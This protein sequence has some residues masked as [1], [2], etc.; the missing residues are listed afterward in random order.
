MPRTR[1]AP[2]GPDALDRPAPPGR[3]LR[4][5]GPSGAAIALRICSERARL[6]LSVSEAARQLGIARS[7]YRQLEAGS[8]PR[9]S[10]LVALVDVL[11][12]DARVLAPELTRRR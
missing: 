6:G 11:G 12:M 10:T 7:T 1:T 5:A 8:D 9:L 2:H 3:P 4:G